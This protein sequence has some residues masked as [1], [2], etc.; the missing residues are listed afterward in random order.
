MHKKVFKF[1]ILIIVF[2][3]FAS[4]TSGASQQQQAYESEDKNNEQVN[5]DV[6][7]NDE[8]KVK[9]HYYRDAQNGM[10]QSRTPVPVSWD[11]S[12]N[13]E[14]EIYIK[15]PN[16][17]TVSK[18]HIEN[19]TYSN[20]PFTL[21]T[22]RQMGQQ[23]W[24]VESLESI[25]QQHLRPSA[26]AQGNAFVKSHPL[27]GLVKFWEK[28]GAG[29]PQTG[30]R[31]QY[32]ALG[33]EWTDNNGT[34]SFLVMVQTI[35]TQGTTIMW[36]VRTT[37]LK[38]PSTHFKKAKDEYL[39]ALVNTEINPEWQQMMNGELI[40]QIN[41]NNAFWA[42]KSQESARAHQQRMAA[43]QARGNTSQSIARTY[44][45]ILDI[46]HAGYLNRNNINNE[47]HQNTVNMI[48]GQTVIGNHDTGEHY[49]V[50]TGSKYYWVNN[51]GEYF[52]T[53]NSL[54]DPRID[55]TINDKQWAMFEVEN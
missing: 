27:P 17:L 18:T 32:N 31:R 30:S 2:A 20:D 13:P 47:G 29:M 9:W 36:S 55:N 49:T 46:N 38:A 10:I 41:K 40:S 14:A 5:I 23:V 33:T 34:Q 44:S 25:V 51:N 43:I 21:Q 54:Y 28:F 1:A 42:M 12:E 7:V 22:A 52:G 26:E 6:P 37:E 50:E 48:A 15:G 45:D 19:Y 53:D 35:T 16:G 24:P 3:S 8:N 11:I 4:C 39:Y